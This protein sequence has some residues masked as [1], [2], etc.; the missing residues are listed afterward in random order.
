M[1]ITTNVS[2][3]WTPLHT[4]PV[5]PGM[6]TDP[7]KVSSQ[8][9]FTLGPVLSSLRKFPSGKGC[10]LSWYWKQVSWKDNV[11]INVHTNKRFFNSA[12]S[13]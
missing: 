3:P 2:S 12:P 6:T 7:K 13:N 4:F 10:A 8:V 11:Q 1:D 9:S 5:V